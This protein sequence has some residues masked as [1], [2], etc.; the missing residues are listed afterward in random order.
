MNSKR[1]NAIITEAIN[2]VIGESF[3]GELSNAHSHNSVKDQAEDL[4]QKYFGH[5]KKHH[6][7][8]DKHDDK[9]DN[10]KHDGKKKEKRKV[11]KLAHGGK[12]YYDYDAYENTNQKMSKGDAKTISNNIDTEK[13]NMAAIA[14]E[15]FPDHT[16]EGAQSQFRKIVNG[17][18]PMTKRIA[19]KIEKMIAAGEIAVK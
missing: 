15:L 17:E 9:H 1:V 2:K 5:P 11:R 16:E 10:G 3:M 19:S 8:D 13:T 12:E 6:K 7:N 14:R 4:V 18:R